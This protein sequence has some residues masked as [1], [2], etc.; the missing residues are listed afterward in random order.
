MDLVRKEDI[1]LQP[2]TLHKVR[3]Y[4]CGKVFT[5]AQSEQFDV[6]KRVNR[7]LQNK[8]MESMDVDSMSYDDLK[9]LVLELKR[10]APNP[11]LAEDGLPFTFSLDLQDLYKLVEKKKTA[12]AKEE[13]KN[14]VRSFVEKYEIKPFDVHET[15]EYKNNLES[16]LNENFGIKRLCCKMHFQTPFILSQGLTNQITVPGYRSRFTENQEKVEDQDVP[17][18]LGI[19]GDEEEEVV[20]KRTVRKRMKGE[21]IMPEDVPK[22]TVVKD[23][24]TLNLEK[25]REERRIQRMAQEQEAKFK[26]IEEMDFL[27]PEET[28]VLEPMVRG[29]PLPFKTPAE[30]KGRGRLDLP[31]VMEMESKAKKQGRPK[32]EKE[33]EEKKKGLKPA[34]KAAKRD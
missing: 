1:R 3:C 28:S 4:N 8:S 22:S 19:M 16:F 5:Q 7:V 11:V 15:G 30:Q 24:Y 10:V 31:S 14:E 26:E 29:E 27:A 34:K 32:V 2:Q 12:K 23:D 18:I 33:K 21:F 17:D 13:L 20:K 6:F 25:T 9:I